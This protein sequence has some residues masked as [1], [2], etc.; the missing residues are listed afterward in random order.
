MPLSGLIAVSGHTTGAT[1]P[2]VGGLALP[3]VP[4]VSKSVGELF[5]GVHM[6]LVW[7]LL[8]TLAI[9]AAAALKHQFF[10]H[11][12]SAGRMP[13]FVPGKGKP[14]VI[15]QGHKAPPLYAARR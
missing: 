2:L 3:V 10:D 15:G 12:P 9:H 6:V 8:A 4:G 5:G 14:T 11:I 7:V 1:T 13:P